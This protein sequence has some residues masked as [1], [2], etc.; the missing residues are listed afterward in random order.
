MDMSSEDL[1]L[2]PRRNESVKPRELDG[3]SCL[4]GIRVGEEHLGRLAVAENK[5]KRMRDR[6]KFFET[7]VPLLDGG[8]RAFEYYNIHRDT[9]DILPCHL[10]SCTS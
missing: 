2:N 8:L 1:R 6:T 5:S 10:E 9:S 3:Q 4:F 7:F